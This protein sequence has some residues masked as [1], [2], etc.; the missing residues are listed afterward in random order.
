M[1]ERWLQKWDAEEVRRLIEG[2]NAPPP[3]YIRPV[4]T[5]LDRAEALLSEAGWGARRV[6]QDVPCLQ[7]EDGTNPADILD[8]VPGL[9]Q[10]PGAALVT[11]YADAPP[12]SK[13]ADLCAAPGGKALA[14]AGAGSYVLAADRSKSRLGV[15]KENLERLAGPVV[16]AGGRVD[17]VRAEGRAPPLREAPFVLLD[18]PCSGTGTLRRHPDAKWKLSPHRIVRMASLQR[19]ILE[20]GADLVPRGGHLVYSTCTL[21]TEED[22]GQ[23]KTFLARHSEFRLDPTA[24]GASAHVDERGFLRV[25]PQSTGFDG[26]F[27]AR[28]V[29][30]G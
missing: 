20:A 24:T 13:V 8:V 19:E 23:V 9:I 1:V 12:G 26:A 21:E 14:F 7:V 5:S 30:R 17:V 4:G 2:N 15:L 22:E 6:G 16:A 3:L 25:L 11:V 10:D 18:V 27:A 29:R 28:M